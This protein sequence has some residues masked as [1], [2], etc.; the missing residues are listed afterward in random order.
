MTTAIVLG[1]G[2]ARGDFEVGA[3]RFLYDQGVMPDVLVGTSVGAINAAKLAEGGPS[4]D[5]T[6]GLKGLESI[7]LSRVQI[8]T[9]TS[10]QPGLAALTLS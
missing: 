3:L 10:K 5:P 6:R 8:R 4:D 1:G 2:G 9:C 7:W